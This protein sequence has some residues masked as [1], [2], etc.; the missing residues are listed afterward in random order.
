MFYANIN[1]KYFFSTSNNFFYYV[2]FVW[3]LNFLY[4]LFSF[5]INFQVKTTVDPIIELTNTLAH[6]EK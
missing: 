6:L 1:T 4:F 5:C 2:Y 3:L